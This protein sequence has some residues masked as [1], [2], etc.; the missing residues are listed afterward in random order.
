MKHKNFVISFRD[1]LLRR[2][3]IF[4]PELPV[5][6]EPHELSII[7]QNVSMLPTWHSCS[8]LLIILD[9]CVHTILYL[10]NRN[11]WNDSNL[12]LCRSDLTWCSEYDASRTM[13][14]PCSTDSETRFG[15]YNGCS[16]DFKACRWSLPPPLRAGYPP[17]KAG[18]LSK[19]SIS[20]PMQCSVPLLLH[21]IYLHAAEDNVVA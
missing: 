15:R 10:A 20:R 21:Y 11:P 13:H 3:Y 4:Y 6:E 1:S 19:G 18:L 2:I 12:N 16:L 14:I 5:Y 17:E 7:F 9:S 8:R